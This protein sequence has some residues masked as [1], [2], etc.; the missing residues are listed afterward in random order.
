MD[1]PKVG[2]GQMSHIDRKIMGLLEAEGYTLT[3]SARRVIVDGLM[4]VN[5]IEYMGAGNDR[6]RVHV[7]THHNMKGER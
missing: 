3:D 2:P 4:A 5:H 6:D 7:I 1:L